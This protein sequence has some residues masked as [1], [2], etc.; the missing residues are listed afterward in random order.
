M[1]APWLC[2]APPLF[3]CKE[4]KIDDLATQGLSQPHER[5]RIDKRARTW[6]EFPTAWSAPYSTI[7]AL[8]PVLCK[9][10]A[11]SLRAIRKRAAETSMC[12]PMGRDEKRGRSNGTVLVLGRGAE[13]TGSCQLLG[14]VCKVD[15]HCDIY[16]AGPNKRVH[17]R[18]TLKGLNETTES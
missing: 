17:K 4:C 12:A 2:S 11:P 5:E 8:G 18:V 9:I 13:P 7:D 15:V 1:K 14:K 6:R 10:S 16:P 3:A